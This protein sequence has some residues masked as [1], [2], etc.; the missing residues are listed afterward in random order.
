MRSRKWI[1]P[2]LILLVAGFIIGYNYIYQDH[3]N[4][5]SEKAAFTLSADFLIQDFKSNEETATSKYLNQ[6][7]EVRGKL[8]AIEDASIVLD[9]VVFF[10]LSE[11]ET[12]PKSSQLQS[13]IRVKG[14]CIG[15]DSLLEEVKL[16]QAS[17]IE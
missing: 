1:Y 15:F 12:P 9:Q 6:T 4:I 7:I 11:N 17:I 3:R 13:E 2:L 5:K 14:R 16:D 8:T 10:A